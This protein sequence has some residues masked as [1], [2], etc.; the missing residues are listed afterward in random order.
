VTEAH[1]RL[2]RD[3]AA[4]AREK[5]IVESGGEPI[6]AWVLAAC[7]VA[8]LIAGGILGGA[9]DLFSYQTIYRP[10]YER[11]PPP[12]VV[13]TGPQPKE[14]LAAYMAKGAKIYS[15]KCNGCH[16][17]D[18]KGDGANFPSLAGSAWVT[19][20]TERLAMIILNGLQ[21]PTSTGKTY[22]MMPPQG[23]G[24]SAADLAGI[25]TY[26]RNHFGNSTGDVVTVDM[27]KAA[28]EI[29]AGRSKAG[30]MVTGAELD[31][32]HAKAL[33]GEPLDPKTLLDPVSLAP[34]AAAPAP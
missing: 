10:G 4:S 15:A 30:Q 3:F 34:A 17:A 32:D 26:V 25:M 2:A 28:M 12:G 20:E 29:S 24:L 5:R 16:G 27:A 33:P 11:N 21:G 23:V 1:G 14:A 31:A 22:G 19:G 13:E 6:S 7:G 8:V 18:A 9:G